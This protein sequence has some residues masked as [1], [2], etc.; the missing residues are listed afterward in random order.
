MDKEEL[1]SLARKV[2]KQITECFGEKVNTVCVYP[3]EDE[4]HEK[5]KL[6][7]TLYNYFV[8]EFQY[9]HGEISCGIMYGEN[10]VTLPNNPKR[11]EKLDMNLF[12]TEME[13]EIALRIPDKY[14]EAYG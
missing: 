11:Y 12:F 13:K 7:F 4:S 3:I 8:I 9:D 2:M 1:E 6:E 14:L 5:I 10:K